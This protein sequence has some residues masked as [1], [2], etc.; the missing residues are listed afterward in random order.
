[1][2]KRRGKFSYQNYFETTQALLHSSQ[3][4][5]KLMNRSKSK[6]RGWLSW[7]FSDEDSPDERRL[8]TK[9]DLLI[10]PYAILAYWTVFLDQA[11]LSKKPSHKSLR[12]EISIP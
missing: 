3:S 1:M 11:N 6:S 4:L 9:L 8:L 12:K 10:V 5:T 2:Y 7:W